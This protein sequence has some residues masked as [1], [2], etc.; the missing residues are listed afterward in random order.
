[1]LSLP[2]SDQS[3]GRPPASTCCPSCST[4]LF[5]WKWLIVATMFAVAI[6]VALVLFLR[7]PLYE[8]KMKILIKAARSQA[9]VNLTAAGARASSRRR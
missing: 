2:P 4:P 9:A 5:K 6:P 7:T 1:M 8:V 3:T